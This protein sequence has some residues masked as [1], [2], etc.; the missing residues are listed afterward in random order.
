MNRIVQIFRV[1]SANDNDVQLINEKK[2][3]LQLARLSLIVC[4]IE[5]CYAAETAFVSPILLKIGLPVQYMTMIWCLSPLAG[6]FLCPLLGAMSDQCH[7]KLGRRRPFMI[8][9]SIGII[10]GLLLIGYGK[11]I[12]SL[13]QSIQTAHYS[14]MVIIVTVIGVF[15]LDFNCD[16]CQSPSRAYLIDICSTEDHSTGLT[17]FTIM[18][19]LFFFSL[20]F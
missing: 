14:L 17:M 20:F 9:Y 10:V 5:F 7:S 13:F 12:G 6:F 11:Q 4:G 8:L 2:T 19:G 16:A 18:A 3:P 15:L 1:D